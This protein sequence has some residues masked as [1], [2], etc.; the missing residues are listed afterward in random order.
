M[1]LGP[2]RE[3]KE[4]QKSNEREDGVIR[5]LMAVCLLGLS[6]VFGYL[7]FMLH[8]RWRD[9][10]DEMGR[11]FDPQTGTIFHQ[12][13]GIFWGLLFLVTFIGSISLFWWSRR[14]M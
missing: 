12:Q 2:A 1:L 11:C 5:R 4:L 13:S 10:F 8:Y 3:T 9:C 7:F 6:V 14:P